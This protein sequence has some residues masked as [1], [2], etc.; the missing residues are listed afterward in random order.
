MPRLDLSRPAYYSFPYRSVYGVPASGTFLHRETQYAHGTTEWHRNRSGL[1]IGSSE[2]AAVFPGVSSTV[3][4]PDLLGKFRGALPKPADSFLEK[5]FAA[6]REWEPRLLQ[7][8]AIKCSASFVYQPRQFIAEE[9]VAGIK[10]SSTADGMAIWTHP[11]GEVEVALIEIKWRASSKKDCGWPRAAKYPL[12]Q[13]KE[14][15]SIADELG[16]TVWCQIQHQMWVSGI[17]IGYVYSGAPTGKRRL[18]RVE[19]SQRFIDELYVPQLEACVAHIKGEPWA[20]LREGEAKKR[21]YAL[22][23]ATT[24]QIQL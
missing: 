16:I 22:L 8:F 18:W 10:Q 3:K 12:P 13:G 14:D 21:I 23:D 6:G 1:A 20:G 17:H 11:N 19:F 15:Y 4:H 5:L 24:H 9:P 2:V 7:E